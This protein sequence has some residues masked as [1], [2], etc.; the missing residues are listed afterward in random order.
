MNWDVSLG[1]PSFVTEPFGT[2]IADDPER[3]D[4]FHDYVRNIAAWLT[5]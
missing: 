3:L 4:I 1:A 2:Q 5:P